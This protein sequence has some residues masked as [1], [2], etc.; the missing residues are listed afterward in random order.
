[1]EGQTMDLWQ[2]ALGFMRSQMLFTAVDLG[3]FEILAERPLT[4]GALARRVGL[5]PDPAGRFLDALC[6]MELVEKQPDGTFVNATEAAERLVPGRPAYVGRII[7]H[8]RDALYP[9]WRFL[10]GALREGCAQWQQALHNTAS[11][12][13]K[14]YEDGEALSGFL[15]GMHAITLEAATEFAA[16]APELSELRSVTDVGGASG[17]FLIA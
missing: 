7:P 6:A 5:A 17:A 11:P 10:P 16:S 14:M 4:A 8:L 2:H 12:T 9:V 15:E 1:M 3:V 13:E